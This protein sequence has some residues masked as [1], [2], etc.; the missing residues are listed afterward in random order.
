MS[1][2][3]FPVVWIFLR[4][5]GVII[6]TDEFPVRVTKIDWCL[7]NSQHTFLFFY[8]FLNQW[9]MDLLSKGC[10][11]NYLESHNSLKLS[12]T[13]ICGLRM[14]LNVNLSLNLILLTFWLYVRQTSM[15][16]LLLAISLWGVIF[17]LS[18]RILLLI[19]MVLQFMWR[20]EF[21]LHGIYL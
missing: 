8:L 11:P 10:K 20:K 16:Q 4:S 9:I 19:Y 13:N 7:M 5:L 6:T 18:E 3:L 17:L 12:F 14:L 15:T 21:F 1:L 2:Q